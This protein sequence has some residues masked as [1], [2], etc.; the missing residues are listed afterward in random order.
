MRKPE[1]LMI[2]AECGIQ[3]GTGHVMRCLALAQAWKR[4]GGDVTFLVREGLAGIEDR[5]RGEGIALETLAGESGESAQVSAE[6]FVHALLDKQRATGNR[7]AANPSLAVLDGYNFGAREQGMLSAAGIRVLTIDD[8]GHASDYPVRWVLNQNAYATPEMYTRSDSDPRLLLG[9]EYALLREEFLPWIGWKRSI[10]DRAG[11]IL[12]TIGGSDPDNASEQILQSLALLGDSS[13]D[14]EVILVAGGGNPHVESL[15]AAVSRCQVRVRLAR[16]VRDMPALM[17]WAD[18]AIAGAGVTSYE[19]CYMGLPSMLLVIAENQRRIAERLYELG[20][21]VNAGTSR[22]F[23]G[24]RFAA[25]LYAFID[26]FERRQAMSGRARGLVDGLGSE[27]VRAALLDRELNLRLVRE[28]DCGL[29]FE[30]AQDPVAR[31]ASFHSAA[32]SW[33]EHSR[34]FA[35]R[36]QDPQSRIYIGENAGSDAV[37]LVR[38][39]IEDDSALLSVNVASRF[40]GEGWGRELI[41]F[42]TRDLVRTRGVRR[43]QAFVKPENHASVR[44][45]EASGFRS[46]GKERIADQDALLFTWECGVETYAG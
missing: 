18:M 19:L 5:I 38:F 30:W 23:R 24:D 44:L 6:V 14:L 32:I 10:P 4:A 11:K 20:M 28:M 39:Q 34:W 42:S 12:I 35:E 22:E 27:R 26:S 9:A 21:A 1:R 2:C 45:F 40:R 36:L 15:Q 33:E 8:F 41:L 43:V 16:S 17:A 46:A 37:G 31:A 3:V 13:R 29:L 25:E 7:S